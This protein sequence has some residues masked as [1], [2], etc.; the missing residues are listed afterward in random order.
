MCAVSR[1]PRR[2]R[3]AATT[4]G[5]TPAAPSDAQTASRPCRHTPSTRRQRASVIPVDRRRA[6]RA[7][8]PRREL[9]DR[10]RGEGIDA[11]EP[12]QRAPA[13]DGEGA[14]AGPRLRVDGMDDWPCDVAVA[15]CSRRA[16]RWSRP[17][18]A[19]GPG[20]WTRWRP[21]AQ[22]RDAQRR[23]RRRA[24][25]DVRRHDAPQTSIR[26]RRRQRL[27]PAP[28]RDRRPAARRRRV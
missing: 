21:R 8:R 13:D 16:S 7:A 17:S 15:R 1:S 4:A 10:V 25:C 12:I 24:G 9:A 2:A 20:K 23:G 11:V 5:T 26:R 3:S 28:A 18:M 14:A 19:T 22:R 27:R 6:E